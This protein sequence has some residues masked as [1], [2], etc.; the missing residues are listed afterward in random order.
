[1]EDVCYEI[2][3]AEVCVVWTSVPI[4]PGALCLYE[5]DFVEKYFEEIVSVLK[6]GASRR[7]RGAGQGGGGRPATGG[8]RGCL[9]VLN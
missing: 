3:R 2:R 4:T 1:M 5:K 8:G 7:G 9:V 6:H